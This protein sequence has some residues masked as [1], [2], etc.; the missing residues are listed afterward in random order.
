MRTANASH[1]TYLERCPKLKSDTCVGFEKRQVIETG[2]FTTWQ[3]GNIFPI[4]KTVR[5]YMPLANAQR[6]IRLANQSDLID[7]EHWPILQG[8][9]AKRAHMPVFDQRSKLR[10][11][12]KS[13][14]CCAFGNA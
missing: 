3:I 7:L 6:Y 11:D 2:I 14:T 12:G 13:T 4:W 5:N 10:A 8:F 9:L 1:V